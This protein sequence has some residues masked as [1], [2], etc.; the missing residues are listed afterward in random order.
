MRARVGSVKLSGQD[1]RKWKKCPV[2]SENKV[3]ARILSNE[4]RKPKAQQRHSWRVHLATRRRNKMFNF[5]NFFCYV[6]GY[7]IQQLVSYDV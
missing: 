1:G 4:Q 5:L 2:C 6:K 3:L 7:E